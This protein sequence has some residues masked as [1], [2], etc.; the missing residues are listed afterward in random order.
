MPPSEPQDQA[1]IRCFRIKFI[2]VGLSPD[3]F[4]GITET[5]AIPLRMEIAKSVGL[6][7]Q[8]GVTQVDDLGPRCIGWCP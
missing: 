6:P 2:L 1:R 7:M 5:Y 8:P 3:D 4:E